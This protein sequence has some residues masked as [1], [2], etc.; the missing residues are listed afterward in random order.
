MDLGVSSLRLGGHLGYR[1]KRASATSVS[2]LYLVLL[3]Y[4]RVRIVSNNQLLPF[5]NE[6][7]GVWFVCGSRKF[8]QSFVGPALGTPTMIWLEGCGRRR[9]PDT[10]ECTWFSVSHETMGGSTTT[11]GVFGRSGLKV[12]KSK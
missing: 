1:Y 8:L 11:R 3:A 6:T 4:S 7:V 12:F 2:L 5:K 10:P 9:P